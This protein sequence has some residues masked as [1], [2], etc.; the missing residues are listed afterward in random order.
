VA[1]TPIS[2]PVYLRAFAGCLSGLGSRA[3]ARIPESNQGLVLAADAY[4]RQIDMT[5]AAQGGGD[6]S[7]FALVCIESSSTAIWAGRSPLEASAAVM[8][9]SYLGTAEAVVATVVAADA[10]LTAL[11]I[12]PNQI[13]LGNTTSAGFLIGVATPMQQ[14]L[15]TL[16]DGDLLIA[17]SVIVLSPFDGTP[18]LRVRTNSKTLLDFPEVPLAVVGQYA[19]TEQIVF[20]ASDALILDFAPGGATTGHGFVTYVAGR[21]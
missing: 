11:G 16:S 4:S 1:Y 10:Q 8:P 14:M 19:N 18:S 17:A 5:W 20:E 7:Q 3:A 2:T 13:G 12:D 9:S 15:T 21:A 6:P